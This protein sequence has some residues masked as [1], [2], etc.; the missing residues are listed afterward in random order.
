VSFAATTVPEATV[1]C[2]Y[3]WFLKS[4]LHVSEES[5]SGPQ[6]V[7][8]AGVANLS[9]QGTEFGA[10]SV[11]EDGATHSRVEGGT[12]PS[13]AW[14]A[15]SEFVFPFHIS[16]LRDAYEDL[17]HRGEQRRTDATIA[18]ATSLDVSLRETRVPLD[19][20]ADIFFKPKDGARARYRVTMGLNDQQRR[21]LAFDFLPERLVGPVGVD[22]TYWIIDALHAEAAAAVDLRSATL[23]VAE[24]GWKKPPGAPATARLS[25]DLYNEHVVRLPEIEVKAAGLDGKFAMALAPVTKQIDRVDVERLVIGNDDVAGLVMRRREGGWYVDLHGPTLD[26]SHWIKDLAKGS[27]SRNSTPGSP[28]QIDARVDRLI[29]GP[30]REVRDFT[31]QLLREGVDWQAAQIEARFVNGHQL[32]LHSGKEEGRHSLTFRSDD[33]GSA[34]SLFD[35]TD[36]IVGGRVVVTSQISDAAGKRVVRGHIE[37]EDYSLVRAPVLARILSLPSFSGAGSMLSGSGIPFST[38]RGDFAYSSNHLVLE[39]LLGYGGA[40]GGTANGTVD[41]GRDRLDLQGTIVP[42]YALNSIIGNIP[43]IGSL[44]LGGEGQGLFAANYRVT[45]SAGDPQISVNPLSALA[46]GFLRRLF[47]PNFGMPP[48]LQQSLG[49]Q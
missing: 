14:A 10:K 13:C 30:Q 37:G 35:I 1:Q 4:H 28:L 40:I 45:G 38:L 22:L 16:S 2:R 27:A 34:L 26:I 11:R 25:L 17:D 48:P 32:S 33:L 39:N 7:P 46:P 44:L 36:N 18:R 31:A 5:E 41:L 6:P 15:S 43:L 47:Q 23:T 29:L 8:L 9:E 12:A 21:R 24:A 42:A 49:V 3:L 19:I 20:D